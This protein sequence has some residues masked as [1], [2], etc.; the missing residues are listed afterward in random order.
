MLKQKS[1]LFVCFVKF[2]REKFVSYSVK[3]WKEH[4]PENDAEENKEEIKFS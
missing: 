2:Q 4:Q 3:D 1:P